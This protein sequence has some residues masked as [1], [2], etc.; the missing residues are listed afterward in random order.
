[1][2]HLAYPDDVEMIGLFFGLLPDEISVADYSVKTVYVVG[3]VAAALVMY[4][5]MV[6]MMRQSGRLALAGGSLREGRVTGVTGLMGG[7][8]STLTALYVVRPWLKRGRTII[9][10]FGIDPE[11]QG[12]SGEVLFLR[13]S[14][15]LE[16]ILDIGV[17]GSF[18]DTLCTCKR[19]CDDH[20]PTPAPNECPKCK[21]WL[22]CSC[23][24]V[25]LVIDEAQ[26]FIPSNN[27]ASL[28]IELKSWITLTRKNHI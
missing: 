9:A 10:N 1:M 22:R 17:G 12:V 18:Y 8:K 6:L 15:F 4:G 14:S 25:K 21:L 28:P 7:G 16:D 27:S 5:F 2:V 23:R 13:S 26:V 11:V 3:L 24:G 20:S 19:V